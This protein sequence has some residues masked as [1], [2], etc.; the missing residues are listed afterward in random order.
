MKR[1][2]LFAGEK[3]YAVGGWDDFI[4]EFDALPQAVA[5]GEHRI[6]VSDA[7]SEAL[8]WYHIVDTAVSKKVGTGLRS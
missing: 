2:L 3:Y 5:A 4:A 1:F 6:T 8:D 7:S